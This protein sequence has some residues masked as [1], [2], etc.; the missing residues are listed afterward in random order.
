LARPDDTVERGTAFGRIVCAV[1]SPGRSAEAARQAVWLSAP[2]TDLTFLAVVAG[3]EEDQAAEAGVALDEA[4]RVAAEHGIAATTRT[5][6]SQNAPEGVIDAS[7][8]A[9]LL[10]VEAG[11]RDVWIGGIASAAVHAAPLPVLV[12]RAAPDPHDLPELVLVATDGSPE[13]RRGL[14]LAGRIAAASGSRA[15]VIQVADGRLEGGGTLAE[16]ATVLTRQLGAEPAVLEAHGDP[17]KGITDAARRERA[18]L[19]VIGSR[20]LGRARVLGSVGERVAHEAPCSVLVL[21]ENAG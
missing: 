6:T 11:A 16:D 13:S 3:R 15:A 2:A 18:S 14:A 17:A 4:A 9:D 20:G 1:D 12:A 21:R 10:V 5:I 7:R 19:V 8:G